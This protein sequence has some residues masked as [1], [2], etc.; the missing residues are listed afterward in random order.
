MIY[1]LLE[2]LATM[3]TGLMKKKAFVNLFRE[4][5]INVLTKGVDFDINLFKRKG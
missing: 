2:D 1:S 3:W 5:K 4:A